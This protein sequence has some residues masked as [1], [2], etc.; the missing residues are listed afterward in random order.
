MSKPYWTDADGTAHEIYTV[1]I[2]LRG[3][4]LGSFQIDPGVHE[5][6]SWPRSSLAYFCG[7]CGDIWAR[8]LWKSSS[9]RLESWRIVEASCEKHTEGT[10]L[11]HPFKPLLRYLPAAALEREYKLAL[12]EYD[13]ECVR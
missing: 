6:M 9:G 11:I 10:L 8:M 3:S 13:E 1:D 2:L 5:D 12:V 7:T 4:D